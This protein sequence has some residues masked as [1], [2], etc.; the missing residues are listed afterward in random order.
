MQARS[1]PARQLNAPE[2]L[3]MRERYWDSWKY[4]HGEEE[5]EEDEPRDSLSP[6]DNVYLEREKAFETLQR[7]CSM[8]KQTAS[9]RPPAMSPTSGKRKKLQSVIAKSQRS[10]V[11]NTRPPSLKLETVDSTKR[12]SPLLPQTAPIYHNHTLPRD[13]AELPHLSPV[14]EGAHTSS[15]VDLPIMGGSVSK[16]TKQSNAPNQPVRRK[17]TIF[18]RHS[19]SPPSAP[20]GPPTFTFPSLKPLDKPKADERSQ[21]VLQ[22]PTQDSHDSSNPTSAERELDSQ[23]PSIHTPPS[24]P[25][26][27]AEEKQ[28]SDELRVETPKL[29]LPTPSLMPEESPGKYGM[30][31]ESTPLRNEQ[32][33][34]RKRPKSGTGAQIFQVRLQPC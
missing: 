29:R 16:D 4:D 28:P 31:A 1:V 13:P 23:Q 34:A 5:Q 32:V 24:T 33:M 11:R 20:P 27:D 12:N 15:T 25:P 8:G 21:P 14:S 30:S 26:Y 17:H 19:N 10:L 22:Q 7:P 2:S 18:R 9:I 6:L 3:S